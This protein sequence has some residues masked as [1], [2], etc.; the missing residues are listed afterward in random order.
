MDLPISSDPEVLE[1]L[2]EHFPYLS[3]QPLSLGGRWGGLAS[4]GTVEAD[5][6]LAFVLASERDAPYPAHFPFLTSD[7]NRALT[8]YAQVQPAEP[9][10]QPLL[11]VAWGEGGEGV[12]SQL[13]RVEVAFRPLGFGQLWYGGETGVLWEALFEPPAGTRREPGA[14]LH[15]LWEL[16]ETLLAARGVRFVHTHG[17]DPAFD[18][19]AYADFLRARGYERDTARTSLPG[20]RAAVKDLDGF[21][22]REKETPR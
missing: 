12:V 16:C 3:G 22:G 14:A 11:N 4:L 21:Y 5:G 13:E 17:R 20:G 10:P 2:Y 8:R 1:T 18:E 15:R 6:R 7:E 19:D 9:W